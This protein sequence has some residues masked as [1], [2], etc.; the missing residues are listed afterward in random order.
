[1]ASQPSGGKKKPPPGA[2]TRGRASTIPGRESQGPDELSPAMQVALTEDVTRRGNM[3]A[4]Q[5]YDRPPESR[6]MTP[7]MLDLIVVCTVP[8][9]EGITYWN[10]QPLPDTPVDLFDAANQNQALA[11]RTTDTTT[12]WVQP[13]GGTN[14][15][16]ADVQTL[17]NIQSRQF[18]Q[19]MTENLNR[20]QT[21]MA[22]TTHDLRKD[23]ASAM[24]HLRNDLR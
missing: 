21:H 1:M 13:V 19:S 24:H 12:T 9:P 8:R 4:P 3:P 18:L 22:A 10:Q 17:M 7:G 6:M 5:H 16:L 11:T 14:V 15:T 2:T 23:S 20:L